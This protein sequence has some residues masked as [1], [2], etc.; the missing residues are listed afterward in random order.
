MQIASIGID[1]GKTTFHLVALDARGKVLVRKKF[2]RSQLLTY[3]ANLQHSLIGME[4][5][6]G[7][8]FIGAA[9]RNQGH[10]VRLIPAQFVKPF[11]KTNKNDFIDAEAVTRDNMRFVPIKTDD[12]LDLQA[13][14]RVRDRLVQRRTA[15]V[16][17]MRGFMLERGIAVA[18]GRATFRS[19]MP[20]ILE[21]ADQ[22]LTP[23]LRNLLHDLWQEWKQLQ[24]DIERISGQI[25]QI[26]VEDAACK[27]LRQIPGVGPLVATATVAAIGNGAAFHKGREFAAWLGL[28]PRQHSTGGNPR[29]FGISKRG[30]S[31]LRRMFVHGARAVLLRVKYDTGGLGRWVQAV[32][33]KGLDYHHSAVCA[34]S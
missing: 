16:N 15:L 17:Q 2:S 21:D 5:C 4:A 9:L 27:R 18:K 8:H 3:T 13:L 12:Q 10:D 24:F 20:T 25:E 19:S 31:Y 32:L 14:H 30:N 22:N 26:S 7:A 28:V 33:S 6:A 1:L 23:R 29:L 34:Q 11:V